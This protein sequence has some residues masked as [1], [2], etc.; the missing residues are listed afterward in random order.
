[1]KHKLVFLFALYLMLPLWY[2]ILPEQDGL[3]ALFG[4]QVC[5]QEVQNEDKP[6]KKIADPLVVA[7]QQELN[8]KGFNA[9][10]VDGLIGPQT[11][12][13]IRAAQSSFNMPIDGASSEELLTTLRAN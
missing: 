4:G 12:S 7:L 10:V 9:G 8:R 11:S 6:A 13:A 3:L 2:T 5:A 1:M